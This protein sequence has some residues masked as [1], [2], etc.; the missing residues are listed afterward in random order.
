MVWKFFLIGDIFGISF[1]FDMSI[2][3]FFA[4]CFGLW[5]LERYGLEERKAAARTLREALEEE[6]RAADGSS[7]GGVGGGI[8]PS[9]GA[10]TY[11][12]H[13]VSNI[14]LG[15]SLKRVNASSVVHCVVSCQDLY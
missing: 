3:C 8:G 13:N 12:M 11:L 9:A 2:V 5:T 6:L 7:S 15:V 14:L 4:C 10:G 1:F